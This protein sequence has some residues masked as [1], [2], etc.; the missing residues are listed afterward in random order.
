MI[1]LA[2][3]SA[4]TLRLQAQQPSVAIKARAM[5][6]VERGRLVENVTVL[7]NE[8]RIVAAGPNAGVSVPAGASVIELPATTLLPGLIDAHVHLTLAGQPPAN[9][10]ATLDAGFTTVQDLGAA[11][12]GNVRLRDAIAAGRVAGPRVIASGPWLGVTGG[13]CDFNGIGVRGAEAFRKRVRDDVEHGVD[14]IKVCV[15]G[16]LADAV[17]APAK[18][19]ISDS[20]LSAAIE[21]A[22]GLGKRVAVHAISEGGIGVAVRMGADLVV[23]GGFPSTATVAMMKER[24]LFE[25]PTLFS[26]ASA[27]PEH[28]GA[29]RAHLRDGVAAGLPVAF[30]TDAGVIPH[31]EN[32]REFE[33][34]AAI[35]LDSAAA[36]RSATVSA[37]R[38]VGLTRDIGLLSPGRFADVIGVEGD[39]LKDVRTLQRVTFVMK[40]GVVHKGGPQ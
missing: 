21:E 35:G 10:R 24:G 4:V 15:T 12:Y 7:I 6:D 39:P 18:Y 1:I 40:Q 19:E 30:G 36:L 5:V 8:G 2:A 32:A 29:V 38:A 20:E 34:L 23:H 16:W 33:Q 31:G 27:K 11:A 13:T 26:F 14:L 17:D 37:A 9:A 28:L 3:A 25:L 22:H